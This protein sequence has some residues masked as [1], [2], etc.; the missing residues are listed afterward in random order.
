MLSV[1]IKEFVEV[2]LA[3]VL[4]MTAQGID[5]AGEGICMTTG[6]GMA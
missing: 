3:K 1:K 4:Q 2:S 6:I 5:Q